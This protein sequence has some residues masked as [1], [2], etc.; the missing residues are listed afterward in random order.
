MPRFTLK[1]G[2]CSAGVHSFFR[3]GRAIACATASASPSAAAQQVV[4]TG[5][6]METDMFV[7]N[8]AKQQESISPYRKVHQSSCTL[9]AYR[10]E[11]TKNVFAK[12]E[13][14]YPFFSR[15]G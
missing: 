12:V 2:N 10:S 1:F 5:K 13:I 3:A 6:R 8:P 7:S 11:I 9:V 14:Q 15:R 4:G